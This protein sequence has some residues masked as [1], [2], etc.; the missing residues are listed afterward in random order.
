LISNGET[1]MKKQILLTLLCAAA[2]LPG[3]DALSLQH[4]ITADA[5][6]NGSWRIDMTLPA[7]QFQNWQSKYGQNKSLV[8]RDLLKTIG[9]WETYD[10]DVQE[11][12]MDRQIS[13]SMKI[14]GLMRYRGNGGYE[15]QVPKQW[16]GGERSGTQF[17]F[18]FVETGGGAIVQN[19]VRLNLP[20]SAGQFDEQR[21]EGGDRVLRYTAAVEGGAKRTTLW[22][23]VGLMALGAVPLAFALR[24][25]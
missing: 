25:K 23:G 3:Q 2:A 9:Q 21:S 19:N 12:Q 14:K 13:I 24:K 20:A 22:G 7:S 10:W 8:R 5:L 17:L 4:T 1:I 18:N 6:G 16:R 15:F 11:R